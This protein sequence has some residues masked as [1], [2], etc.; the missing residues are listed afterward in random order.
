MILLSEH[1]Y[2]AH[3]HLARVCW[4]IRFL[5]FPENAF[6][7]GHVDLTVGRI[8]ALQQPKFNDDIISLHCELSNYCIN[9]H[10]M[11]QR[12]C[13]ISLFFWRATVEKLLGR[14]HGKLTLA[15]CTLTS[16]GPSIPPEISGT[17]LSS[18]SSW[19]APAE[20]MACAHVQKVMQLPFLCACNS[21]MP[22]Q[23]C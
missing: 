10:T 12:V 2:N 22:C 19:G 15:G 13:G 9:M 21:C 17:W 20:G 7:V 11:R 5:A 23:R 8:I 6:E 3:V 14:E 18:G 1:T 16:V 4:V